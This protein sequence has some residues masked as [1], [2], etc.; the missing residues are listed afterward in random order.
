MGLVHCEHCEEEMD[1][2]EESAYYQGNLYH[3]DCLG[4]ILEAQK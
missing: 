4:E 1:A 3:P 2:S